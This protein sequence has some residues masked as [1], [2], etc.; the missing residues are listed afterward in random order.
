MTRTGKFITFEGLDGSG[1]STQMALAQERLKAAGVKVAA[2]REPGGTELGRRI[3]RLVL[4]AHTLDISPVAELGLM[5]SAR[6]QHVEELIL[7]AL[8]SGVVVL[9]DRFADSTVAY[10]GYGRGLPLQLVNDLY[11]ALSGGLQ[12][13][14]TLIFD[15]DAATAVAR[16]AARNRGSGEAATRFEREDEAFFRRVREGYL[17]IA[18]AEPERVRLLDGRGSIEEVER[19]ARAC[20]EECLR[21]APRAI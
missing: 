13:D 2:T 10:Q 19:A 12:P 6:A 20:I 21:M 17:A 9:C 1:K 7:P 15:I 4:D 3:R 5:C 8:R 16:T 18:R 14:L 11:R